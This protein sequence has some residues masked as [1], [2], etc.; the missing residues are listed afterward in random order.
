MAEEMWKIIRIISLYLFNHK[1]TKRFVQFV[2]FLI[3]ALL[4]CFSENQNICLPHHIATIQYSLIAMKMYHLSFLC[5]WHINNE[6]CEEIP[7]WNSWYFK[8]IEVR[9]WN[10]TS[11]C[12]LSCVTTLNFPEHHGKTSLFNLI[13]SVGA[14]FSYIKENCDDSG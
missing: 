3:D 6:D 13:S 1:D 8:A 14:Y 2:K 4:H 7:T 9:D 5:S 10:D 11:K 12:L